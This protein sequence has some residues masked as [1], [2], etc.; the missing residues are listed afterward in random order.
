M[1]LSF[2]QYPVFLFLCQNFLVISMILRVKLV[3]ALELII[4]SMGRSLFNLPDLKK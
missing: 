3:H 2:Y 4:V 1:T